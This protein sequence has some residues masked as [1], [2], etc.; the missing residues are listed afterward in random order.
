MPTNV[1]TVKLQLAMAFGQG[2]GAMLADLE[3]LETLL[4]ERGDILTRA[5]KDWEASQWAFTAL[6]RTLGQVSA[7]RAAVDGSPMIRWQHI[8]RSM[9]AVMSMCPC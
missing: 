7:V 1:D 9:S 4:A 3:A 6:V 8:D 5:M 2:A